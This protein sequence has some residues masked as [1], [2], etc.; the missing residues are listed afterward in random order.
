[1][2]KF[3]IKTNDTATKD[4]GLVYVS[5]IYQTSM[6][7][8][9][10]TEWDDPVI[11]WMSCSIDKSAAERGSLLV[12]VEV[13]IVWHTLVFPF[14]LNHMWSS[15]AVCDPLTWT[16]FISSTVNWLCL[17]TLLCNVLLHALSATLRNDNSAPWH[18]LSTLKKA[19]GLKFR[20]LCCKYCTYCIS[21]ATF[22]NRNIRLASYF[23]LME[24]I[25]TLLDF[26]KGYIKE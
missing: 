1:M 12:D 24:I 10:V 22:R 3:V 25:S 15:C 19:F 7:C 18:G 17:H 4:A 14:F 20:F 23:Y 2:Y 11:G 8:D 13:C 9:R 6:W 21:K 5:G 26:S 16:H